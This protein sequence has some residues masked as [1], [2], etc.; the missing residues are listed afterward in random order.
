MI[1]AAFGIAKGELFVC[2]LGESNIVFPTSAGER[3]IP[4]IQRHGPLREPVALDGYTHSADSCFG[5][6]Y[7]PAVIEALPFDICAEIIT[8]LPIQRAFYKS[9]QLAFSRNAI[10]FLN[11]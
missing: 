4:H 11:C 9:H 6:A 10:S 8:K 1:I 7:L 3:M 2:L 5:C